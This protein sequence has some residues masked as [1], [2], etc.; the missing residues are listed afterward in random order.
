MDAQRKAYQTAYESTPEQ[1]ARRAA[2]GR[3]R[4]WMMKK[5]GEK[6]LQGM[7]VD[8]KVPLEKGGSN[9]MSNL[10]VRSVHENRGADRVAHGL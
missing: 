8:H 10:R 1:K 9:D 6:A 5:L 2:R 3:A 4:Y 7:D